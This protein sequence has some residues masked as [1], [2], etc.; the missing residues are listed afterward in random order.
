MLAH[1]LRQDLKRAEGGEG[2][3]GTDRV[4]TREDGAALVPSNV[5]KLF[6]RLTAAA[7]LRPVRLHDL[8]HGAASL[9]LSGGVDVAVVSK[10]LG[11]SSIRI[12][13]DTYGHPL[14]EWTARPPTQ[15]RRWCDHGRPPEPDA[16]TWRPHRSRERVRGRPRSSRKTAPDLLISTVGLTSSNLRPLDPQTCERGLCPSV[17]VRSRSSGGIQNVRGPP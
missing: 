15:P 10:R 12:T 11:H 1:R 7:G 2:Y 5:T 4:F 3:A 17:G 13:A 6:T 9:M 16:P 14:P 8:R